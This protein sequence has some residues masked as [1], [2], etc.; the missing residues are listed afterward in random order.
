MIKHFELR[1]KQSFTVLTWKYYWLLVVNSSI[2]E[3]WNPMRWA[4]FNLIFTLETFIRLSSRCNISC[5]K[6]KLKFKL[7]AALVGEESQ[8]ETKSFSLFSKLSS[9]WSSFA[10]LI[11]RDV[12]DVVLRWIATCNLFGSVFEKSARK[13]LSVFKDT[14][15]T[16][17][18]SRYAPAE[19]NWDC[20]HCEEARKQEKEATHKVTSPNFASCV[21]YKQKTAAAAEEKRKTREENSVYKAKR[22]LRQSERE[23]WKKKLNKEKKVFKRFPD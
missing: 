7:S 17:T 15:E 8:W 16:L 22:Y 9:C 18:K 19:S 13:A 1:C 11:I 4:S 10:V 14:L 6:I 20:P 12:F 23:S 5:L 3:R 21:L 2:Q